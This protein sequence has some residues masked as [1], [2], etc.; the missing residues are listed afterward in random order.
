MKTGNNYNTNQMTLEISLQFRP[1]LNHPASL[2]NDF[3][4]SL[5][6][7][8]NYIF[9]RPQVY[10]SPALLKLILFA[11]SRGVY[12]C[13]KIETFARE[14]KYAEWL[15][16]AYCPSYRTIARF[17]TSKESDDI[18]QDF[19]A[20]LIS[21]LRQHNLIDEAVYIDGTKI[22]ANANKYSFVWRK[23]TIRYSE[24]NTKKAEQ[25][26]SDIN[27]AVNHGIEEYD[28]W[29]LILARLENRIEELNQKINDN[30]KLSPNPDKQTR[31]NLK[32]KHCKLKQ[33]IDK[34]AEYQ[35]QLETYGSRNSYSKTDTDATF[36]RLKEDHM[37]NGQTKPAYN[38]QIATNNQFVL[39]YYIAQSPNDIRTLIP[40]LNI[41][42]NQ[43]ALS[44][45]IIADAGYGSEANYRFIEDN[46][47]NYNAFIPYSTMLIEESRKWKSDDRKV[48]NWEYNE[49][50]DY[51][52][53]CSGVRFNFLR[54]SVKHN[55]YGFEQ[56]FKVYVAEKY[57]ENQQVIPAS[58]T[59][60]GNVKRIYI[61]P[62]WEYFKNKAKDKLSSPEGKALYYQRKFDVEPVL[63]T[64]KASLR[65]TRFT[66]RG[67]PKV[68]RQMALVIM[69]WNMKKLANKISQ[70][71]KYPF[72]T[73]EKIAK[74]NLLKLNFAIF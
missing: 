52:V 60:K 12:S 40:F 22:Q 25:L 3:V 34:K 55:R 17:I 74:F 66:V 54:Y 30:P 43:N 31:R 18:F 29:E 42:N 45:N 28:D 61:N 16:Q 23:N 6:I 67:L 50:D 21:I 32:S 58:L 48:M 11:Y 24:L 10:S 46:F 73:K 35:K 47:P 41:L 57:D 19:S 13:R 26:I 65:F 39:G 8:K 36:M 51:F 69:A 53:N 1:E 62:E 5:N 9:G 72:N 2:I 64:L 44:Q 59:P 27:E 38:L 37:K 15:V 63:G 68:N 14:N 71:N 4:D 49:K 33:C 56:K 20:N 7:A 70:F